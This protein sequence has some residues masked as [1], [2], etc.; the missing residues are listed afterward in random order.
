[1]VSTKDTIKNANIGVDAARRLSA[2]RFGIAGNFV[3]AR[4]ITMPAAALISALS[5]FAAGLVF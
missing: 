4:V 1:V 3:G 5:C 2:L